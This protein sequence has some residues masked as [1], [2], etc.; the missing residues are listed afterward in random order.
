MIKKIVVAIISLSLAN[1][2]F[3]ITNQE[4]IDTGNANQKKTFDK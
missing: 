1:I 2:G 4:M 3:S